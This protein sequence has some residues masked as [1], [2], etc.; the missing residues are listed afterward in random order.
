MRLRFLGKSTQ[1]GGSPTLYATDRD[2]YVVQGWK[3]GDEPSQVE[4]PH[5]L[6]AHVEPGTCLGARLIDTGRGSFTLAGELVTDVEAWAQMDVPG[7]ETCVEVPQ[8]REV[9]GGGAASG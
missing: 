1:G 2:T 7:H 6:L 3:V 5:R 4:I 8:G 9:W